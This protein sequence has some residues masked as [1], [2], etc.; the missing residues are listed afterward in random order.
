VVPTDEGKKGKAVNKE[1]GGFQ[2]TETTIYYENMV[3]RFL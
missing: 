1:R 2:T 3:T